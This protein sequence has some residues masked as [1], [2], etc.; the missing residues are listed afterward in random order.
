MHEIE[1][2]EQ[3]ILALLNRIQIQKAT[4]LDGITARFLKEFSNEIAPA[5]TKICSASLKRGELPND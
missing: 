3:G 2:Q 4:G 5:L 1:V